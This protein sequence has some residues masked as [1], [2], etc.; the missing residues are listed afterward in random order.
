VEE[1]ELLNADSTFEGAFKQQ[2]ESV[3]SM[4]VL[5]TRS[6][7]D[8]QPADSN[9]VIHKWRWIVERTLAWI[10]HNRRFAKDFERTILSA[11]TFVWIA[12]I[13]RTIKQVYS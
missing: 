8:N 1:V 13:R 2:V 3:P 5:I 10:N 11:Q 6:P 12:H 7:I 4:K 9:M